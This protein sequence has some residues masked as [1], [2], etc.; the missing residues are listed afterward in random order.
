MT[1]RNNSRDENQLL[2]QKF[3][4]K[5]MDFV[6]IRNYIEARTR[7]FSKLMLGYTRRLER[8]QVSK[9]LKKCW[10]KLFHKISNLF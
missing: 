2:F 7:T 4:F 5:S 8:E 6:W 9:V 3:T 1:L 10:P